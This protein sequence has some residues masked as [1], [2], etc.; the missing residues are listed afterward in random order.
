MIRLKH[1]L[2]EQDAKREDQPAAA[3]NNLEASVIKLLKYSDNEEIIDKLK[4]LE[5]KSDKL[6]S[7]MVGLTLLWAVDHHLWNDNPDVIQAAV[8][9]IKNKNILHMVD[10]YLPGGIDVFH[11]LENTGAMHGDEMQQQWIEGET[12][13]DVRE[14]LGII[15]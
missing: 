15:L 5:G 3:T 13:H 10:S 12:I 2:T 6:I 8:Q 11:W 7:T 14:R 1:I 9:Q 4:D